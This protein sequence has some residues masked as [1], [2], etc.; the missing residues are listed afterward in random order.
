MMVESRK[1]TADILL[2]L[3]IVLCIIGVSLGGV[4]KLLFKTNIPWIST[5]ISA[6]SVLCMLDRRR[7]LCL[8]YRR[9]TPIIWAIFLYSLITLFMAFFTPYSASKGPYSLVN[10]LVYFA[11]IVILWDRGNDIDGEIFQKI[12]FGIM[13]VSALISFGLILQNGITSGNYMFN[14]LLATDENST[15]VSRAT[16]GAIGFVSVITALPVQPKTK[17]ERI[18]KF[19]CIVAGVAVLGLAT[20][21]SVYLALFLALC[22]HIRNIGFNQVLFSRTNMLKVLFAGCLVVLVLY[23]VYTMNETVR[24]II[25]YAFQK[26]LAGLQT[27]LGLANNDLAA[28]MRRETIEMIPREYYSKSTLIQFIFGRGYMAQWLDIPFMQ[29][30]WDLGLV[31][32]IFYFGIM[33][34]LP[35]M[36]LLKPSK[37]TL[38]MF[39]QYNL[40]L[41]LAESFANGAPYGRFFA[42]IL[43]LVAEQKE[44][45]ML[46]DTV[47]T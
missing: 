16:M 43:L 6:L 45:G 29:A 23:G 27:Y 34:I 13:T 35:V 7:I 21:R 18:A 44:K 42:L 25:Q 9:P 26:M 31:G 24:E 47:I 38:V 5:L 8:K 14:Y 28:N 10:Q 36:H 41:A 2:P 30:F 17:W 39:A 15:G 1:K 3:G 37:N 40:C 22:L 20:R 46:A 12:A 11:Q 32:G 33:G 4:V 19:S